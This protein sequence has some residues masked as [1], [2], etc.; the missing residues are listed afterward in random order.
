MLMEHAWAAACDGID[1]PM[2]ST[3]GIAQE[4][5]S[6]CVPLSLCYFQA[7]SDQNH[8]LEEFKQHGQHSD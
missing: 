4:E 5:S 7:G 1:C 8:K 3:A 6:P 2:S